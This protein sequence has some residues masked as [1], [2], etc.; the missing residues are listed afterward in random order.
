MVHEEEFS[1]H[2]GSFMQKA[3]SAL[4]NRLNTGFSERS[5]KTHNTE[6]NYIKIIEAHIHEN[7]CPPQNLM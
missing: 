5:G 4:A 3:I 1:W 6:R 7:L 2:C